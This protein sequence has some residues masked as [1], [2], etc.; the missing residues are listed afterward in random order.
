MCYGHG[1]ISRSLNPTF[2]VISSSHIRYFYIEKETALSIS[3]QIWELRDGK[4]MDCDNR[5]IDLRLLTADLA[6]DVKLALGPNLPLGTGHLLDHTSVGSASQ[7]KKNINMSSL[8]STHQLSK[9]SSSSNSFRAVHGDSHPN[10][11]NRL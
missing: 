6:R 10:M 9:S 3:N 1:C 4:K 2:A 5:G 11:G 7:R 8:K